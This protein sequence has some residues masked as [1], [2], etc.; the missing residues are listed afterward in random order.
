MPTPEMIL[1]GWS[2]IANLYYPFAIAWHADR[3]H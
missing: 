3:G 2:R 1:D